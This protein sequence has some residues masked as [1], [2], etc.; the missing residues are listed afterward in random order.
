LILIYGGI[1]AA[2]IA[3][4]S[5]YEGLFERITIFTFLIWI[6]AFSYLLLTGKSATT[7]G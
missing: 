5:P 7:K 2:L 3:N 4:N 1:T 6:M